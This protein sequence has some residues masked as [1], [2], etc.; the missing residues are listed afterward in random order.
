MK[1]LN[2]FTIKEFNEYQEILAEDPINE[3]EV[4]R[5][6]GLDIE[7]M[8]LNDYK[9]SMSKINTMTLGAKLKRVYV[10]NG[11]RYKVNLNLLKINAG[12]F[13]DFQSYMKDFKIENILSIFMIPQTKVWYGWKDNK[14]N[15][16]YNPI[17]V[18]DDMYNHF[19]MSDAKVLSDF[20]LSQST[21]LL[22]V[23]QEYLTKKM[24]LKKMK[25]IKDNLKQK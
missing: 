24:V 9:S 18:I 5:I 11:K 20:F 25:M 1:Q 13:I 19:K 12:Q 10:V 22:K 3:A 2:D 23:M 16:G 7:K 15:N 4:L 14:Y 8:T 17:E 6:F 21:K